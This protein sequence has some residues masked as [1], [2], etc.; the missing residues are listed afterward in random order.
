MNKIII[1]HSLLALLLTIVM[2]SCSDKFGDDLRDLGSRVEALE[3]NTDR[4]KTF[5][6]NIALVQEIIAIIQRNGY[7]SSLKDNGD[8]SFTVVMT[9]VDENGNVIN[10]SP[11]TIAP[12]KEGTDGKEANFFISV[13]Q[14]TDGLWYWVIDKTGNG[15]WQ[16]LLDENDKMVRAGAQDGKD[17]KDG[18]DAIAP[19]VRIVNGTDGKSIWQISTDGGNTWNDMDLQVSPDG[20]DG[21]E[22]YFEYVRLSDDGRY[23]IIKIKG[24][25]YPFKI[26]IDSFN[27]N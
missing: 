9:Y 26:P 10:E 1:K 8:G 23:L 20:V 18:Q 21:S 7:I 12:G 19:M 5:N 15:D 24:S 6:E 25:V 27:P 3:D 22:L 11:K 14:Y 13:R 17:G 16:W 4:L 2:A